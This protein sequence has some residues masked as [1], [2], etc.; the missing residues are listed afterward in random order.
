[1]TASRMRAARV[2]RLPGSAGTKENA[3]L[4][5][6]G[7]KF[8]ASNTVFRDLIALPRSLVVCVGIGH[9]RPASSWIAGG[10]E[11]LRHCFPGSHCV[12]TGTP[13][14]PD[15]NASAPFPATVVGSGRQSH[16]LRRESVNHHQNERRKFTQR[17]KFTPRTD[18]P[19]EE[20][21]KERERMA[22]ALAA[23]QG[24]ITRH[25]LDGGY[26]Y[27]SETLRHLFLGSH[28][29]VPE[30]EARECASVRPLLR[31][32]FW[33]RCFFGFCDVLFAQRGKRRERD[34]DRLLK[35]HRVHDPVTLGHDERRATA[36]VPAAKPRSSA[37]K[38]PEDVLD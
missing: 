14:P 1:M 30:P 8:D 34:M 20:R 21:A 5:S 38:A 13:F 31:F 2:T 19:K 22:E 17:N 4:Q 23:Y 29:A 25:V 15:E 27:R 33:R 28:I 36:L 10:R 26:A 16:P 24:P 35:S 6:R 12:R 32:L 3:E 11:T 37:K 7:K 9:R 18:R